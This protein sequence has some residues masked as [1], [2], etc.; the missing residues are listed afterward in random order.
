[1]ETLIKK[2]APLRNSVIQPLRDLRKCLKE[3]LPNVP[4]EHTH[5]LSDAI[6]IAEIDAE[7]T[8][9]FLLESTLQ[10][11]CFYG[12][13]SEVAAVNAAENLGQYF[14]LLKVSSS[15]ALEEDVASLLGATFND[16]PKNKIM[17]LSRFNT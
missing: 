16:I 17:I 1:M 4:E 8:E 13:S 2:V 9:Q 12:V 10:L 14:S 7:H 6:K 5:I 3:G 11:P 15:K